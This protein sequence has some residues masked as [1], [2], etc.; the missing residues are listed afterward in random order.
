MYQNKVTLIGF[1]GATQKLAPTAQTSA[2]RLFRC[3]PS[4]P[5]RRTA[6]MSRTRNGTVA[7]YSASFPSSPRRSRREHMSRSKASCA[8]ANTRARKRTRSSASGK[9]G[10]LQS[11]SWIVPRNPLRKIRITMTRLRRKRPHKARI[12]PLGSPVK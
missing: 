3:Q 2:S 12:P 11:S 10:S 7:S 8:A 5:T 4:P 1:L 9:S 6:S